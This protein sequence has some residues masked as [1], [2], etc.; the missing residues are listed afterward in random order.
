MNIIYTVGFVT[1]KAHKN[2]VFIINLSCPKLI[3][4]HIEK[5]HVCVCRCACMCV[6]ICMYDCMCGCM[7][8]C[9]YGCMC[10][11]VSMSMSTVSRRSC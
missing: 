11:Y 1:R 4:V 7:C 6:C 3:F 8:G 5:F 2:R 10:A 9:M